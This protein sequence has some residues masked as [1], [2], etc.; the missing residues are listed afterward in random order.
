MPRMNNPPPDSALIKLLLIGDGKIGKTHYAGM[1]AQAGL[2]LLYLDGDV[3]AATIGT[4]PAK[5]REH[6]YLLSMLDRIDSGRRSHD[7]IDSM[8]AFTTNAKIVWNDSKGRLAGIRDKGD[9]SELWEIS[10][11]KLDHN[12]VVVIDSWTSLTESIMLKCALANG[13]DLTTATTADMRPVYQSG[14]LQ[15][16][17]MLQV[18]RAMPCHVIVIGHPDEYSHMIKPEGRT[19]GAV[20][21]KDLKIAWT[22]RIAKGTSKP[23]GLVMPKYFTDVAWAEMNPAGTERR[24]NF[25][26]RN[27]AVGGG[28]FN[29]AKPADGEYSF[30]KLIEAIGGVLPK[31]HVDPQG[32]WLNIISSEE[33][34]KVDAPESKVL[35]GTVATPVKGLGGLLKK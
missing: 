24:L 8:V 6:I 22:K 27:D 19:V 34:T 18:I 30:A 11:G 2:N 32:R 35:D 7:F 20:N 14:Q 21:E 17:A 23:A 5:A 15:A 33:N 13:V 1:A 3:G 29:D 31:T 26:V 4:L 9:G 16:T 12:D 10:P 28:H 25:K